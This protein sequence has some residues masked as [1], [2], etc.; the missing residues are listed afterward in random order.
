MALRSQ[1]RRNRAREFIRVFLDY[2]ADAAHSLARYPRDVDSAYTNCIVCGGGELHP[3]QRYRSAHLLRCQTCGL[4]FAGVRP[5]DQILDHHYGGYGTSWV[6]SPITRERY[7]ELL[8]RL[9]PYRQSNRI[10]DMGCGAG[11][12]LEEAVK[13]GWTAY[14]SEFGEHAL[15]L[16]SGRGFEVLPAPLTAD[17][18]PPGHFDVVTSFEVVE[19]LRDPRPEA[20]TLASL[21]RPGGAFYCTTPNFN[22]ITR[23]L[24]GEEWRVIG[25][26]E[27]L[28][29]F[30][31]ATLSGWLERYGF[32][33][34]TAE[35]T[36]VT[37]SALADAVRRR[38]PVQSDHERALDSAGLD[39]RVRA[40]AENGYLR[41]A[42]LA[43]N[44]ALSIAGAGDTL[45]ALFVRDT[46]DGPLRSRRAHVRN[47]WH[48]RG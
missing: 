5:T 9:E 16:S 14:G 43:V 7:R 17:A 6:D 36:G 35:T 28:I 25:Y 26:P 22:S 24:L 45:K 40:A 21:I 46:P 23:H 37:P 12:F 27:H 38:K 8:D 29:Y 19:H 39:Q 1:L 18:F 20:E 31:A 42:K 32:A 11:Y 44:R 13:R 30:T 34:E 10:L 41:A 47:R 2:A 4:T 33:L 3:L 48:L 15:E